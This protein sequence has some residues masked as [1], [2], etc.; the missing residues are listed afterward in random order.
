[1]SLD[2]NNRDRLL[3]NIL[4][5]ITQHY[6]GINSCFRQESAFVS[7]IYLPYINDVI[8]STSVFIQNFVDNF[9]LHAGHQYT[10]QLHQLNK[11]ICNHC[12]HNKHTSDFVGL[13]FQTTPKGTSIA[14]SA[15]KY[16]V[17]LVRAE[18]YFGLSVFT[19]ELGHPQHISLIYEQTLLGQD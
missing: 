6:N 4:K 11:I 13:S 3:L 1:M 5:V 8:S 14:S 12:L 18:K 16:L 17:C 9:T 7:T 15:V 19:L 2:F 10:S